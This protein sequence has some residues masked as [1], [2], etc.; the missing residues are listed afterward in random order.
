MSDLG[1]VSITAA[2]WGHTFER[3][4]GDLAEIMR[5]MG[6][7]VARIRRPDVEKDVMGQLQSFT[8]AA[9]KF[10]HDIDTFFDEVKKWIKSGAAQEYLDF[11]G[12]ID[13]VETNIGICSGLCRAVSEF[14]KGWFGEVKLSER[15]AE[16][17]EGLRKEMEE[18]IAATEKQPPPTYIR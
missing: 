17:M 13:P 11:E 10:V 15:A 3:H 6:A 5:T 16:V 9:D 18:I 14:A 7:I 4:A 1:D 2:K 8:E 12:L